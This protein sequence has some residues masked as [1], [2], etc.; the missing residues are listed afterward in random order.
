M[1]GFGL[2]VCTLISESLFKFFGRFYA[3]IRSFAI[4][5]ENTL[6]RLSFFKLFVFHET[7]QKIGYV[8]SGFYVLIIKIDELERHKLY[9]QSCVF[10][11]L[12]DIIGK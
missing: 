11:C 4:I 6:S 10:K 2:W 7:D 12:I 8:V 9:T 3:I 5:N 1:G